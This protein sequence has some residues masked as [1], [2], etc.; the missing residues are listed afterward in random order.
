MDQEANQNKREPAATNNHRG[1][2]RKHGRDY[3]YFAEEL[4]RSLENEKHLLI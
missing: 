2:S 4:L 1:T 3:Q